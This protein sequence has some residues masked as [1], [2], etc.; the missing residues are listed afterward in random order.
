MIWI[1]RFESLLLLVI[2]ITYWIL[3]LIDHI[4]LLINHFIIDCGV[5]I[6]LSIYHNFRFI[7]PIDLLINNFIII[8]VF[9]I[10]F[11]YKYYNNNKEVLESSPL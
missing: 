11:C 4:N 6:I 8:I 1:K 5:F 3:G 2:Q 7:H 9:L 10:E